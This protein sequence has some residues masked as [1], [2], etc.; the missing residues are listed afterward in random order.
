L[1]IVQHRNGGLEALQHLPVVRSVNYASD[2]DG[3]ERIVA[4]IKTAG[5]SAFAIQ[6]NISVV[7]EVEH[8]FAEA[9]ARSDGSTSS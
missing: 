4:E 8:L 6:A 2:P 1:T 3:A 7:A 9:V 5:G